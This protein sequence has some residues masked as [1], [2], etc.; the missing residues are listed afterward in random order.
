MKL[1]DDVIIEALKNGKYI[2]RRYW[3]KVFAIKIMKIDDNDD[4]DDN[5]ENL[6]FYNRIGYQYLL[7]YNDIYTNDW[8]VVDK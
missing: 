5:N 8:E 1:T 3:H 2:K 7:D 6:H 4:N